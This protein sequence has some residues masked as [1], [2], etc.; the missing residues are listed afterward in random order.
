M[1]SQINAAR[2]K[3]L[4]SECSLIKSKRLTNEELTGT[5]TKPGLIERYCFLLSPDDRPQIND[6]QF[7]PEWKI[8][9]NYCQLFS[10]A[11]AEDLPSVCGSRITYD[12][13]STDRTK[14][15]IGFAAS[16]GL[17]LSQNHI[18]NQVI[19]I[20]DTN[21]TVR[22]LEAKARRLQSLSAYSRENTISRD[23]T[24]AFLNECLSQQRQP[25]KAHFNIISWTDDHN[26]VKEM[27]NSVSAAIAQIDATPRQ[28]IKGAAQIYWS[29]LPGN[30]ADIPTNETFDTFAEQATCFLSN[31]TNYKSTTP[32][33]GIRFADRLSNKPVFEDLFDLPRMLGISNNMGLLCAGSSG[34]GKSMLLNHILHSL[35]EQGAH[36]MVVDIGG[37]YKGLCRITNGYYFTYEEKN[38]IRFNPF[39]LSEG[40]VLDTEKK[41]P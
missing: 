31:E 27:R 35:W 17:L 41:N 12:K 3:R 30:A 16:T 4:L 24:N 8:G 2:C 22:R 23:A 21:K 39:Y 40:E 36:C 33:K 9:N 10:L 28:E 32:D 29:C 1:S 20:E 25:V 37:S 13:Y 38:P 5:K 6:I 11:D 7:K 19:I 18:Y 26:Q 15:S 14:F 34:S